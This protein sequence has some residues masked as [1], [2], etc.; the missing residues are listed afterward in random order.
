[1]L[2]ARTYINSS[3]ISN[4]STWH[5]VYCHSS[6][7]HLQYLLIMPRLRNYCVYNYRHRKSW[8]RNILR[9]R[10]M[11]RYRFWGKRITYKLR[12]MKYSQKTSHTTSYQ[13]QNY[14]YAWY[15]YPVTN[16]GYMKEV[17]VKTKK[18]EVWPVFCSITKYKQA[19]KRGR[20]CY[21]NGRKFSED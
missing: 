7:R 2:Y 16:N 15:F 21:K 5:C 4:G 1:M 17:C 14:Y 6:V 8:L 18:N 12:H 11:Y 9:R 10:F 13:N 20:R 19:Y 3:H